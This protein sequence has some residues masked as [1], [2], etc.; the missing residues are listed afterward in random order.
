MYIQIYINE[1][2]CIYIYIYLYIYM[3]ILYIYYIYIY[4]YIY[5]VYVYVY[6]YIHICE[7]IYIYIYCTGD[8]KIED[9]L[10]FDKSLSMS[11]D[12]GKCMIRIYTYIHT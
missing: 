12:D 4:I 6:I 8:Y 1:Y 5:I 10:D 9:Y 3:C 7:C 11:V 2:M